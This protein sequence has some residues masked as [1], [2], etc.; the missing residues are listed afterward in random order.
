MERRDACLRRVRLLPCTRVRVRACGRARGARAHSCG[1]LPR[2]CAV[3]ARA[4]TH[5]TCQRVGC[6]VGAERRR[7]R[8]FQGR[9][10]LGHSATV[11][12]ADRPTDRPRLGRH[13]GVRCR[14]AQPLRMSAR[15]SRRS[16]ARTRR[17]P[18]SAHFRRCAL[19]ASGMLQVAR[20]VPQKCPACNMPAVRLCLA[21]S[22]AA[23]ANLRLEGLDHAEQQ[24]HHTH[25]TCAPLLLCVRHT[26]T[27]T[28][29]LMTGAC[30]IRRGTVYARSMPVYVVCTPV[31]CI[32]AVLTHSCR[33]A[34][35][36]TKLPAHADH[37]SAHGACGG[38]CTL[39][40]SW[41]LHVVCQLGCRKDGTD[42]R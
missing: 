5:R 3:A 4:A 27:A 40:A 15:A 34:R 24:L 11:R 19:R 29:P 10:G 16:A 8:S 39:Y 12:L 25:R 14:R 17:P 2:N 21:H 20:K 33:T 42:L 23:R 28:S 22:W 37:P 36:T 26:C 35:C 7:S 1:Y 31:V 38:R 41:M 9:T 30:D 18:E 32:A 13:C 6:S